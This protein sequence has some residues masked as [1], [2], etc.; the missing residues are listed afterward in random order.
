MPVSLV[1]AALML[2]AAKAPSSQ[3]VDVSQIVRQSAQVTLADRKASSNYDYYET[4]RE[5][6]G[7][8]TYSVLMLDGS[9]YRRLV[10]VNGAPLSQSKQEEEKKKLQDEIA[11]RK[12]ESAED[13]ARRLADFQK[14]EDRD[15]RFI[16]EFSE[17]FQFR[18]LAVRQLGT[19]HVYVIQATPLPGYKA[20]D[21]ESEVLTGMQGRLFVDKDTYHWV[22]AEAEVIHP[23]SIEGFL[24]TVEPGT[25]FE[26][27]KAPVDA[28]VW[29]PTHF[30]MTSNAK[31][32][33]LF[34]HRDHQNETYSK[35]RKVN[36]SGLQPE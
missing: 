34:R 2:R 32:L 20:T 8:K 10:A 25:R 26:L 15:L 9:P 35:Y 21:R 12:Q 18:L 30:L 33:G 29:L 23:V 27:D 16:R 24:A 31:V 13:R 36:A 6:G 22:Q 14:D 1:F 7:S 19:H 11:R 5:P 4:D 3:N 17:A 28:G